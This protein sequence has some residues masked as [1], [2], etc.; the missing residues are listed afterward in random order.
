MPETSTA[1]WR[2]VVALMADRYENLFIS[3]SGG[4]P[5]LSRSLVPVL[6]SAREHGAQT[7]IIT[8]GLLLKGRRL[9]EVA[10]HVGAVAV[11]LDGISAQTHDSIR[12]AGAF[13][14]TYENLRALAG[15]EFNVILNITVMQS[16]RAELVSGLAR[17]VEALPFQVSVDIATLTLEGRGL[18]QSGQALSRPEFRETLM[19]IAAS[20]VARRLDDRTIGVESEPGSGSFSPWRSLPQSKRTS[21][22]YGDTFT[23]FANGDVSPCLTPRFIRGNIF[24]DGV[25]LLDAIDEE[26]Q[27]AQVSVLSECRS[28]DLRNICGGRCH[29]GQLQIGMMPTQVDCPDEYKE[30]IYSSLAAWRASG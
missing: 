6:R 12:G 28:C 8:N 18:S 1:K 15:R 2:D 23:V 30:R 9:D 5:L 11:S 14:K 4:E 21:C 27:A 16:N 29:L 20:F 19:E 10:P 24:T 3:I 25:S 26:R 22:G 13:Q 17:F 7:A